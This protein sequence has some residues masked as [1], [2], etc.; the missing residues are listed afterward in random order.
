MT[1]SG[2]PSSSTSR[3]AMPQPRNWRA[4]ARLP[5]D[6]RKEVAILV[7]VKRCQI[8]REVGLCDIQT[9]IAIEVADRDAHACLKRTVEIVG[10]SRCCAAFLKSPIVHV[11]VEEAW[12]HVASDV[13]IGPAIVIEIGCGN[14]Q[15]VSASRFQN[16]RFLRDVG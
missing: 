4:K 11:P 2:Q 3:K 12:R 13:D 7:P 10:D 15:R 6:I 16:S 14:S 8:T 5:R 1:R 9:A